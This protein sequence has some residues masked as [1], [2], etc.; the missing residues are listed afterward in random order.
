MARRRFRLSGG[1]A[2]K[3]IRLRNF[4]FK[5]GEIEITGPAGDLA[6]IAS[7]LY[8]NWQ[9]V[10]VTDEGEVHP[11]AQRNPK[12]AVPSNNES[13]G[14]NAS[15][16]KTDDGEGTTATE[17][18]PAGGVSDRDGYAAELKA[19]AEKLEP[20]NDQHWTADGKPAVA[21]VNSFMPP[22]RPMAT[23]ALIEEHAGEVQRP[24]EYREDDE[25]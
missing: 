15:G 22:G 9:A 2:G 19:A 5:Q 8:K 14:A 16:G 25:D 13:H 3:T 21:A 11:S 12:S 18:G 10:E 4:C 7:F 1:L 20:E 23:R 24:Q 17:A 6:N